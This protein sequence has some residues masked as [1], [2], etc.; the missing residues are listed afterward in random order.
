[1]LSISELKLQGKAAMKAN[2][3]NSVIAGIILALFGV[4]AFS[5]VRSTTSSSEVEDL[6]NS[7]SE[8]TPEQIAIIAAAV[9]GA[10]LVITIIALVLKIFVY[11]PLAVGAYRF[12]RLNIE[13]NNTSL[14]VVKEGFGEYGRVFLTLF[15][16]DLFLWL[17]FMLF[18]IPGIIKC[19][20]Y[21]LVPYIIKD[22]PELSATEV[23]TKS[24]EMMNGY[25]GKAFLLDLSFI[26][27]F[28]LTGLTCGILG[29]FFTNPYYYNTGAALYADIKKNSNNNF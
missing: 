28:L 25:K 22:N 13:D 18:F 12:F 6:T 24:R 29:V 7:A 8:L 23:I 11:N 5:G 2:Y 9:I 27:W 10:G 21:R 16:R 26:G 19:Y 17:W 3:K 20:S 1:M 14:A 4:G 15:L